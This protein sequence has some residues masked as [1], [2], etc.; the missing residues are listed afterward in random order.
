MTVTDL[1]DKLDIRYGSVHFIIR[2]DLDYHKICARRVPEQFT[3]KHKQECLKTC[4]HFFS[5]IVKDS[6]SCNRL[7]QAVKCGCT[8]MNLLACQSMEWKNPLLSRTK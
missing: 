8:T 1:D 4:M 3:D 5:D 7:S 2:E 6:I